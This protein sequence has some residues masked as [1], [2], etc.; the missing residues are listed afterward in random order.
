M[1]AGRDR[2]WRG[3][4]FIFIAGTLL[5]CGVATYAQD[6][7]PALAPVTQPDSAPAVRAPEDIY[8]L[9]VLLPPLVT[10]VFAIVMQQV[11]PA[12]TIGV[13]VASFMFI[14]CVLPDAGF[15][16][17][18]LAGLRLAAEK[19]L[20]GALTDKDHIKILLFSM[21]IG[22][23][24]GVIAANGGTAAL[25]RRV[26]R[27]A[28]TRRRGQL[29]AWAAGLIVFFDDYANAMI[30]GPSMRPITD[31]LKISRAKLA[32]I[33]DSTAAPVS[34]LALV[35]TWIGSEISLIQ[36]GLDALPQR[37][38]FLGNMSAFPAFLGS[39]PFRFYDILALVMV[40]VIAVLGRDFGAM[41]RSENRT[42]QE[43][44]AED[45]ASNDDAPGR[46][47]YAVVPVL[48]LLFGSITLL[49][50][51]GWPAG[52]LGSIE[53]REGMPLWLDRIAIILRTTDVNNAI[54]YGS[55]AAIF[56]ALAISFGTRAITLKQSVDA[57]TAT[58]A[59]MFPTFIVLVLAW[60][61]AGAM[62][63]LHLGAVIGHR[64]QE[65]SFA[66]IWL[67]LLIF[68]SACV[69]SFA[70]GTSW[71]TMGILCPVTVTVAAGLM[72]HLPASEALPLFYGSIGAVLAGA[73]FGDHCSPIS[74]TTVI[75]SLAS[76]CSVEEHVWTQIPYALTVAVVAVLAG[77][78]VCRYLGQP[79][80]IG[81]L[82]GSGLLFVIVLLIGRRPIVP[83][84]E[85]V[86]AQVAHPDKTPG[87]R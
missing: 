27:W 3:A 66:P 49:F 57:A 29:S 32:Y 85:P 10:I 59:R 37:P 53:A 42:L 72:A 35:G 16:T 40:F 43:P 5:I 2:I 19:H 13:L 62:E 78:G 84:V 26:S 71:G 82:A 52:G 58:M 34:S 22:G 17:G 14:P 46:A 21:T 45:E 24:V 86:P 69:V 79:A 47:W 41:L 4:T 64:L 70:T 61:F 6:S 76:E 9:W 51:G 31:R 44:A 65:A 81:L 7:Q 63:D 74:D 50:S 54:L 67:P 28:S 12:L 73:V 25:V 56:V 8:G 80:W 18:P 68:S 15:G 77:D 1:S 48:V 20:V 30:V 23:M 87:Q 83:A 11:I 60:T 33:V 39:L 55:F 75:S 38:E 36:K